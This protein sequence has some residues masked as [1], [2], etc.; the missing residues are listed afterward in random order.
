MRPIAYPLEV[1]G[2]VT[3]IIE[4]GQGP[5]ILFIHGLGAR[6]DRWTA[7]VEMLADAGY[8][9]ITFDLP[10]HG[11]ASKSRDRTASAGDRGGNPAQRESLGAGADHRQAQLRDVR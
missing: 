8:R 5:V 2:A 4:A 10:G 7:M 9:A 11:F 1:G 6:A 3:R